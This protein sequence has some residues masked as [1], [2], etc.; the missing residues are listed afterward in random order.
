[1]EELARLVAEASRGVDAAARSDEPDCEAVVRQMEVDVAAASDPRRST[2][3]GTF[4]LQEQ[5]CSRFLVRWFV[6]FICVATSQVKTRWFQWVE[7][8]GTEAGFVDRGGTRSIAFCSAS[9]TTWPTSRPGSR[10]TSRARSWP[11]STAS[12]VE[13]NENSSLFGLLFCAVA[14]TV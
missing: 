14:A 13:K 3:A 11:P 12:A 5:V 1:M 4:Q 2:D 6:S 10:P 8:Y 7:K 9:A